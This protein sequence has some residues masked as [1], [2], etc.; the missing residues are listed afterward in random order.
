MH[1]LPPF[2]QDWSRSRPEVGRGENSAKSQEADTLRDPLRGEKAQLAAVHSDKNV[3]HSGKGG[4]TNTDLADEFLSSGPI[5]TSIRQVPVRG[6][7][8]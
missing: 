4:P 3:R 6:R 1:S 5:G 7:N 8:R 2:F